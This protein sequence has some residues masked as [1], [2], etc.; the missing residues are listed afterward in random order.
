MPQI[1]AVLVGINKYTTVTPLDGCINDIKAVEAWLKKSHRKKGALNI[2]RLTDDE[3]STELLPTKNNIIA[4]FDHFSGAKD[5]DI[6]LFYYCGHG[7]NLIAPK[8]FAYSDSLIQALVCLDFYGSNPAEPVKGALTDKELGFL[9]WKTMQDKPGVSFVAITDCCHSGTMTRDVEDFAGVKSTVRGLSMPFISPPL[10]EFFG[11][12]ADNLSGYQL[13]EGKCSVQQG[14]HIHFAAAQNDEVAREVTP[15]GGDTHGAFTYAMLSLLEDEWGLL[16]YEQLAAGIKGKIQNYFF[17]GSGPVQTPAITP[18]YNLPALVKD[19][20]FLSNKNAGQER[21]YLV[22]YSTQ[23]GWCVKAGQAQNISVDDEVVVDTDDDEPITFKVKQTFPDFS[24]IATAAELG[25]LDQTFR[26]KVTGQLKKTCRFYFDSAIPD[27]LQQQI[28]TAQYKNAEGAD[29]V[30]YPQVELIATSAYQTSQNYVLSILNENI[31]LNGPGQQLTLASTVNPSPDAVLSLLEKLNLVASWDLLLRFDNAAAITAKPYRLDLQYS[32]G[33]DAG[34]YIMTPGQTGGSLNPIAYLS[35]G[36]TEP[37]FKLGI[38]NTGPEPLHITFAYLSADYSIA[39]S[40]FYMLDVQ[41]GE[42]KW[43]RF[44]DSA[45]AEINL[46]N[47]SEATVNEYLKVC[48]AA[49]PGGIAL[50]N[51]YQAGVGTR[52][53][54]SAK[55][56]LPAPGTYWQTETIGFSIE[57]AARAL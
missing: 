26:G 38:T 55:P 7:A 11:F 1:Y 40:G 45:S 53:I 4:A 33:I 19:N 8:E 21:S 44:Q 2:R 16:S 39:T 24:V 9:I 15:P 14:R 57:P 18:S 48:I 49:I 31:I 35:N 22:Q 51:L 43:M 56:A 32:T 28:W 25:P 27:A 10:E 5:D 37:A 46:N 12:E 52:S 3:P 34:G 23:Y 50:D 42:T 20:I 17:N 30:N 36:S 41:P 6:C 13:K 47:T 29:A 54:G